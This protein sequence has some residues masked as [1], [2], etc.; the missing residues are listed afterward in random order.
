[1]KKYLLLFPALILSAWAFSQTTVPALITSNQVWN[2][3]GSP[4]TIGQNTYI[5]TGVT[6]TVL[7][8]TEII[9]SAKYK[10]AVSGEF[11]ALG[12]RD[13]IIEISGLEIEFS[14]NS[15]DYDPSTGRGAQFRYCHITG[16]GSGTITISTYSTSLNVENCEFVNSYYSLYIMAGGVY[17]TITTKVLHSKFTGDMYGYGSP[18]MMNS[19]ASHL[20][21]EHSL[22]MN[23]NTVYTYGN[24]VFKNNVFR[25]VRRLNTSVLHGNN[26]FSCNVFHK[27]ADGVVLDISNSNT[28]GN[29]V[30]EYNTLDSMGTPA[31]SFYPNLQLKKRTSGYPAFGNVSI[32][33]NNFMT[34]LSATAKVGITGY[35][36]NPLNTDTVNFRNNWWD[37]SDPAVIAT[38]IKDYNDDI[39]IYGRADFSSYTNGPVTGCSYKP[40]CAVARF[41]VSVTDSVASFTDRSVGPKY[42]TR[43]SF[44]DGSPDVTGQSNPTHTYSNPGTYTACLYV[45]DTLENLCDSF[46]DVVKIKD[47]LGCHAS[48]YFA[49]DTG[50]SKTIYIVND[51]RSVGQYIQYY[52][53]FGDG[54]GTT[55][56]NPMH[57]YSKSGTYF[58]CLTILDVQDSCY[59]TVCDSIR[60]DQ[61]GAVMVVIDESDLTSVRE[62]TLLSGL[63]AFPNP[64]SDVMHVKFRTVLDADCRI[65]LYDAAG[66]RVF[67]ETHASEAGVNETKIDLNGLQQGMY[68]LVVSSPGAV[69]KTKVIVRN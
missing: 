55:K 36:N 18:I 10:L 49:Y 47:G 43:W 13:S 50:D 61:A 41:E 15:R 6:V 51:S 22:F 60:I 29:L 52:W 28:R 4:Y 54:N 30:F 67:A 63:Q 9:A 2:A 62:N 66:K 39:N 24:V 44:G 8:G 27:M 38:Y 48:F 17:D 1:M 32:N 40:S 12:N 14:K 7:P 46:C 45:Y 37:S 68:C 33:N 57:T 31:S 56:K 23:S 25:N 19:T 16:N 69:A 5:D 59:R 42:T 3:A 34:N 26:V 64:A 65:E 20:Y 58:V 21:V 35:N 53:S 11:R